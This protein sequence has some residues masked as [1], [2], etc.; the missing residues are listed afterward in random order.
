MLLD[1][2]LAER[3]P[4]AEPARYPGGTLADGTWRVVHAPHIERIASLLG[5]TF[6]VTYVLD[7]DDGIESH[8][9]YAGAPWG[10]GWLSTRGR[11]EPIDASAVRVIWSD[12]WWTPGRAAEPN[13]E[14]Q[15]DLAGE[16]VGAIGR[17]GMIEPF[18]VFPLELV[19]ESLCAFRF[20]LTDSRIV[21]AKVGPRPL[22]R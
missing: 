16:L 15:S 21:A 12:I 7:N 3:P 4:P 8:V 19:D 10:Q 22:R 2:F 5:V 18:S 11:W 6:E 17:L 14:P 20:Q 13:P 1:R 9:R